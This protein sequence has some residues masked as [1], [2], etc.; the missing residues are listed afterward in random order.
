MAEAILNHLAGD[1]FHALSAGMAPAKAVDPMTLDQLERAGLP[2]DHC[3]TKPAQAFREECYLSLDLVIS[4]MDLAEVGCGRGWPGNPALLQWRIPDPMA[5]VG[6]D[7][8]RRNH[9]RSAFAL[10]QTRI[11]LIVAL[12]MDRLVA[13]A[14]LGPDYLAER[15]E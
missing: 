9:F 14:G 11:Q 1:A 8:G 4:A 6:R 15:A 10:L 5:Y 12:P 7:S 2:T 3:F 13:Q